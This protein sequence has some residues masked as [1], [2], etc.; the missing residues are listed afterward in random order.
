MPQHPY[1]AHRN[2]HPNLLYLS[3]RRSCGAIIHSRSL[4]LEQEFYLSHWTQQSADAAR[5]NI[6]AA[7]VEELRANCPF[8]SIEHLLT[9]PLSCSYSLTIVP[10]PSSI[11]VLYIIQAPF[12]LLLPHS[13]APLPFSHS[14][15]QCAR[16]KRLKHKVP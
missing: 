13:F 7:P 6:L 8:W 12:F 11:S 5:I 14:L 9:H 16:T 15:P 2:H 10:F 3:I 1:P 4:S